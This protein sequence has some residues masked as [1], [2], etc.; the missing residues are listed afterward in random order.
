MNRSN[1]VPEN[2]LIN[3]LQCIALVPPQTIIWVWKVVIWAFG[4]STH[5]KAIFRPI[6]VA[7]ITISMIA[8]EKGMGRALTGMGRVHSSVVRSPMRCKSLRNSSLALC[9]SSLFACNDSG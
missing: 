4:S 3:S 7:D 9:S 1:A 5:V 6:K 2:V 8:C